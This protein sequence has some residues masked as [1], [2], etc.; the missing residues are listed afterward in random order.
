MKKLNCIFASLMMVAALGSCQQD[1]N[2]I[3]LKKGESGSEATMPPSDAG[4]VPVVLEGANNGGNITCDE[5]AAAFQLSPG[6]FYCGEKVDFNDGTFAGDFPDGLTVD[7]TDGT[8]V[9]FDMEAPLVIGGVEYIV[10][11]VIV[12]GGNS[13]N[14]YFYPGGSMADK[15]LSSP[16]NRSGKPAGLSNLSFCLVKANPIVIALKTYLAV[17]VAG[18][19]VTYKRIGWAVSG[20]L[21]VSTEYGLHM[22]YNYYDFNG[23]NEFDLVKATLGAIEGRVGT[24]RA[25]D[26]WE[27]NVH[28]LEVVLNIDEEFNYVFDDTYLYVGSLA[29]YEGSWFKVFP[30]SVVGSCADQRVF[31][32]SFN[33][34][35][36]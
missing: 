29:G 10:G 36:L 25:S 19:L 12:K 31:R 9:S 23:E 35:I 32:I 26:Y 20:G 14:V 22:G 1:D 17:P 18:E 15:G 28:Y 5:V 4:I 34:I 13:A 2:D 33:E 27:E 21:G 8:Y 16:V 30:W 3:V 7:V 24:I 11:A 6:Y